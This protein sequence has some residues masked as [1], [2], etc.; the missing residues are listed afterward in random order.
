MK[1]RLLLLFLSVLFLIPGCSC[2]NG[3]ISTV[4]Q[5]EAVLYFANRERTDLIAVNLNVKGISRDELPAYVMENLLAG[6][7]DEKLNRSIRAGTQ[8]LSVNQEEGLVS[9]DV[10]KEYYNEESIYDILGLA[11]VVKSLCSIRGVDTVLLTVEGQTL[12]TANGEPIGALK[13]TD[14]VFDADALAEDE[15][16]ITLYFS[17]VNAE[18]LVR[19]IRRIQVSRGESMEKLVVAELIAGPQS[20][21]AVR[22][23]PVETKIRS[24]ETKNGVCFVNL[25]S[26]FVTKNNVGVSAEQLTIYSLVNSLTE[27]SDVDKVQFLIEGEKKDVYHHIVFNE[28]IERDVSMIQK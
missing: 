27:L 16:N 21:N 6:P 25:S 13:E 14:V 1:K 7:K 26:E 10:S 23:I 15:S 8:L 2:G 18:Y 22:T 28:P 11:A 9:V 5:D 4:S 12:Q 19:E 24:V 3:R 20:Q 17:D